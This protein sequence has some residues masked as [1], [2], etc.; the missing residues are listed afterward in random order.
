[1]ADELAVQAC[2][3]KLT[4]WGQSNA[5]LQKPLQRL[6]R[7]SDHVSTLTQDLFDT[8]TLSLLA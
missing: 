2:V 4:A 3:G 8:S 5:I 1:M 6:W 7:R